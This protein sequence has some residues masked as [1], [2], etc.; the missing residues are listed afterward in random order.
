MKRWSV[1]WLNG[2]SGQDD[3]WTMRWLLNESDTQGLEVL[4]LR[5]DRPLLSPPT[6]VKVVLREVSEC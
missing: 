6:N 4:H 1:R 2:Q 3:A 5:P